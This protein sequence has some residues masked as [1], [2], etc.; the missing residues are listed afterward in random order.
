M[1]SRTPQ[2]R[3]RTSTD[4]FSIGSGETT[5]SG[6][7]SDSAAHSF[8]ASPRGRIHSHVGAWRPLP[9]NQSHEHDLQCLRRARLSRLLAAWPAPPG[10]ICARRS[11]MFDAGNHVHPWSL[12]REGSRH[13]RQASTAQSHGSIDDGL[14]GR[15]RQS[16]FHSSQEALIPMDFL[17]R[18]C[19]TPTC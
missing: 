19:S 12:N 16:V 17:G 18:Y 10:R 15:E 11:R 4:A 8:G 3:R 6:L 14:M 7:P 9:G 5:G 1:S 2:R 13:L